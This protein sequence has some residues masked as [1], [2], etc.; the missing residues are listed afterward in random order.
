MIFNTINTSS[1]KVIIKL[2]HDE[3]YR[4]DQI[5]LSS[6]VSIILKKK[7]RVKRYNNNDE[8]VYFR[9]EKESKSDSYERSRFIQIFIFK[10]AKEEPY[11]R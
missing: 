1:L 6:C 4:Y 3:W 7:A 10:K 2:G 11:G 5:S 8:H 9:I